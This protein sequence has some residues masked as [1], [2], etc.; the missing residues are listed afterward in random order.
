VADVSLTAVDSRYPLAP[1]YMVHVR[2]DRT[3]VLDYMQTRRILDHLKKLC[4]GRDLPDLTAFE[5]FDAATGNGRDMSAIASMLSAA[6]AAVTGRHEE[7]ATASI[8]APGG[9]LLQKGSF[10]GINDF[11][12]VAYLVI[13][14]EGAA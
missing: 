14:P 13:L 12:V 10:A 5:R 6:V 9:T 2:D 7:R 1:H 4:V 3:V 8:F 11:E